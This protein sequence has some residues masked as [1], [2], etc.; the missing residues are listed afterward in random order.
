MKAALDAA[1]IPAEFLLMDEGA[2]MVLDLHNKKSTIQ[3][4][5]E[6]KKWLK[7][8]YKIINGMLFCMIP[9]LLMMA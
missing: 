1:N 3:W 7:T 8:H 9:A 4:F 6:M 5:E 2:I